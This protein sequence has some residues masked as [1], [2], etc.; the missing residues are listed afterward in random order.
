[1]PFQLEML[2]FAQNPT[3]FVD[4]SVNPCDLGCTD[5][6]WSRVWEDAPTTVD[7]KGQVYDFPT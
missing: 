6:L 2:S 3:F 7:E 5:Q 4:R 1:M